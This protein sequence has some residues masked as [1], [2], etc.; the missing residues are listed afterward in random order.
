MRLGGADGTDVPKWQSS[1]E[2]NYVEYGTVS[3]QRRTQMTRNLLRAAM[4]QT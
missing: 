2:G 1:D 3:V 4:Q